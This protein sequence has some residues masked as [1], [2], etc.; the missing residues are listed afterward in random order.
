MYPPGNGAGHSRGVPCLAKEFDDLVCGS[1][2]LIL[3]V[4]VSAVRM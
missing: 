4:Q 3:I 1:A 2:G